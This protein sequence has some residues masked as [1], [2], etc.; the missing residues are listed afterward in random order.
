MAMRLFVA[1]DLPDD[2]VRALHAW[3]RTAE[4]P[5]LRV[6]EPAS[7]H[8]TLAFLGSRPDEEAEAIGAAAAA[9]AAPVPDL[10]LGDAAWLGRG[11]SLA[12]DVVDGAG[13]CARLQ[14][15]V[16]DALVA[17]GVFEPEARRF[18]PH[19]TVARV[20]RGA[21]VRRNVPDPPSPPPF[22]GAAL[23]LYES[24]LSPAGARYL[25]VARVA[26]PRA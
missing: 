25:P 26:L 19:V 21:R 1:L 11:S 2:V 3:A 5:G 18:R 22:A 7:L 23:T 16:S 8:V 6:L 17:L 24:R 4:R 13:A 9:C 12:V 20:R 15:A 14:A 10:R